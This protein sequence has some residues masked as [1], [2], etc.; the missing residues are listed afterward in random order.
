MSSC[1]LIDIKEDSVS[2]IYDTLKKVSLISANSGGIGLSIHKIRGNK[3]Y[4]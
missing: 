2:G 1:F 3:S 4:I